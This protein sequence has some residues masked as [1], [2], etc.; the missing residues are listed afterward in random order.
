MEAEAFVRT[1]GGM[2]ACASGMIGFVQVVCE[3][4]VDD[5]PKFSSNRD[6]A[7]LKNRLEVL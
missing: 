5:F 4:V 3:D 1:S 7:R 6:S 2:R